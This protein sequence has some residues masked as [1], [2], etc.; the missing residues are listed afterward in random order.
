MFVGGFFGIMLDNTIPGKFSYK[1]MVLLLFLCCYKLTISNM[2]LGII[3]LAF[4]CTDKTKHFSV[5]ISD[6]IRVSQIYAKVNVYLT[7]F[8]I[9]PITHFW[10]VVLNLLGI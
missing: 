3:L 9:R 2:V 7:G 6:T 1:F 10:Q 4:C 8:N 5:T